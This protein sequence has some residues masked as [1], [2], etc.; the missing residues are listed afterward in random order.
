MD[1]HMRRLIAAAIIAWGAL[2]FICYVFLMVP[3]TP[4][5]RKCLNSSLADMQQCVAD[6]YREKNSE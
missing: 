3:P 1:E 5:D 4:L 2:I 6:Y